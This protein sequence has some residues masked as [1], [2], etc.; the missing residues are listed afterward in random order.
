[1]VNKSF[2]AMSSSLLSTEDIKTLSLLYQ[3]LIG[4]DSLG[5]YLM[6]CNIIN[7]TNLQTEIYPTQYILDLLNVNIQSLTLIFDKLNAIG[8]LTTFVKD[9]IYLF[10]INMPLKARQFFLDSVLG[11]YLKSEVGEKNFKL[12]FSYFSVSEVSKKGYKNITKAFDEVYTTKTFDPLSS[13]RFIVGR[14]NAE[15]VIIKDAFDFESFYEVLPVRLKK[16]RIFTKKVVSQIASSMYVYNFTYQEMVQILS[17]AYD[18][19]NSKIFAEKIGFLASDYF[20]KNYNES[21]ITFV[22]QPKV[23]EDVDL[24]SLSPQDIVSVIG[25]K[26]TNNSLSLNTIREFI[27]RNAVDI[28]LINGVIIASIKYTDN[29]PALA[30][31]EKVLADWLAKGITTGNDALKVLKGIDEAP[32]KQTKKRTRKVTDE[33]QW[34]DDILESL[35]EEEK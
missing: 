17:N 25:G 13:E 26:M 29:V 2:W 16:R 4:S 19:E 10:R 31:L 27:E 33:P 28:G 30:Y 35:E 3:P 32:K 11:S 8:L 9:E 7:P 21:E 5:C 20:Q 6:L 23:D 34:L 1:M 18:E 24:A 14:K 22:K 12:L 15:G